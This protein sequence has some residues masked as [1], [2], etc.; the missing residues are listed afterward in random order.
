[1]EDRNELIY[2]LYQLGLSQKDILIALATYGY[3]LSERHLRRILAS[4]SLWRRRGYSDLA[5]VV[6]FIQKELNTSGCL[7]GYKWMYQKC[8]QEGLTVRRADI[9][10]ILRHLDPEGTEFR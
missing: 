8:Q 6:R 5:D 3:I 7:H 4:L 9:Q 2:T 10:T 1:M